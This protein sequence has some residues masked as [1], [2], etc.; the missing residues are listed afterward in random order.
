MTK[1][2]LT[3]IA[4]LPGARYRL[5][6]ADERGFTVEYDFHAVIDGGT[7]HISRPPELE[8]DCRPA[9]L[10]NSEVPQLV[11]SFRTLELF[12]V[13]PR[14]LRP[15]GGLTYRL[16]V[17]GPPS[18]ETVLDIT[19]PRRYAVPGDFHI[20]RAKAARLAGP[21]QDDD[22]MEEL[23]GVLKR[24][25]CHFHWQNISPLELVVDGARDTAG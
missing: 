6:F 9:D 4:L 12:G 3:G 5:A 7:G 20:E 18:T 2:W 19:L 15:I 8:R 13:R 1:F 14:S 25:F 21:S 17:E 16:T 10:A 24:L 23:A 11:R 22:R